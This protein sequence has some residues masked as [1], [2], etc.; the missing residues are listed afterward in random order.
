MS[1]HARFLS[2]ALTHSLAGAFALAMTFAVVSA[3]KAETAGDFR[4]KVEASID[5]RMRM[6]AG[7]I[8]NYHGTATLAVTVDAN[9]K[10]R[11]VKLLK[12]AGFVPFDRQAIRTAHNVEYPR[13]ANGHTVAMVLGFNEKV[14]PQAQAEGGEI[15]TAYLNNQSKKVRLADG[16][17]A[18]QPDS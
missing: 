15:V 10:V 17:T 8:G 7:E 1:D 2:T 16:T 11:D 18:Q 14:T 5:Q 9:G 4:S 6:P 12:S 3:A 13:T